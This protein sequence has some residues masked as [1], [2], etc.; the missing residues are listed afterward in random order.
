MYNLN[1]FGNPN[2]NIKQ[3]FTTNAESY[4]QYLSTLNEQLDSVMKSFYK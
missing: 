2:F 1:R 4:L 3:D